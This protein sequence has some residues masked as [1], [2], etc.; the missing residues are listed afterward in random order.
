VSDPENERLYVGEP[1]ELELAVTSTRTGE[2]VEPVSLSVV[3]YPPGARELPPTRE[4]LPE[5]TLA[6]LTANTYEGVVCDEV[7]EE[8]QWLAV[9]TSPAP[10][11]A[12]LP[13]AQWVET[14]P[15]MPS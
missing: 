7:N 12:I 9:V 10:F 4:P 5:V 15:V 1:W 2:P 13:V 6:K 11:K 14:V 3:V 8:G